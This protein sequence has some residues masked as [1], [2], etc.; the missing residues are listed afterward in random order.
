MPAKPSKTTTKVVKPVPK[1][2][3]TAKGKAKTRALPP[4]KRPRSSSLSSASGSGSNS[5]DDNDGANDKSAMLAALEAQSRAMLGLAPLSNAGESSSAAKGKKRALEDSDPDSG[6]NS[7]VGEE[8]EGDGEEYI[9]DD[10]WGA[11]DGFVSDSEDEFLGFDEIPNPNHGSSSSSTV[12]SKVP[13]VVFDGGMGM[14]AKRDTDMGMSKAERRAFMNGNSAKMM[15]LKSE[16]DGYNSPRA[17]KRLRAGSEDL[18]EQSNLKLDQTLHKMLL[19]TLL[20]SSALDTVS[21]PS[22][23]RNH[24]Q[25][26]LME[27]ASYQLPGEGIQSLKSSEL[28]KLPAHIRTGI[29]HKQ[30][31]REKAKKEEE[32]A[33]GNVDKRFGG[34]GDGGRSGGGGR[35]VQRAEV[36]REVGKK[37]GM[38]GRTR[39]DSERAR[40]LSLGVG[41]FQGGTLKLSREEIRSVNG[42][43]DRGGR[44]GR[45]G[46]RG[47]RG[48]RG[49]KRR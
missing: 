21:R 19:T 13:E 39:D 45:G 4:S 3:S 44:G 11:D 30:A 35:E 33:A 27:L 7:D 9:S 23:K 22:E 47:G 46:K 15:G 17:G 26:R 24:L 41:R 12:K 38:A 20:P 16:D 43:G 32:R 6:S 42:A 28:S 14:G 5:V 49:G 10:G 37:K 18:D 36:G 1:V 48:E 29:I 2:S 40:G 34:L 25:G 8:E 31:K